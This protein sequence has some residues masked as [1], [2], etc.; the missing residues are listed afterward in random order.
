[1]R[2]RHHFDKRSQWLGKKYLTWI[3]PERIENVMAVLATESARGYSGS[4]ADGK[5]TTRD[6][7]LGS[8]HRGK[9]PTLPPDRE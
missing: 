3:I 2:Q 4:D 6:V 8:S 1:M 5:R 7:Q 9:M